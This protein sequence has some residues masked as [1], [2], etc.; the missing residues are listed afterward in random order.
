MSPAFLICLI[1]RLLIAFAAFK[2]YFN[3]PWLK[4][5]GT[6]AAIIAGGFFAI[7]LFKL[8]KTGIETSGKEIWWDHL[9]PVHALFYALFALM[10]FSKY[11]QHAHVVLFADAALGLGG[12][13]T[14]NK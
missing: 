4:V 8:R 10:T 6:V 13:L 1:T 3:P 11:A 12:Y 14:H 9:R 2:A 7:W 5:M